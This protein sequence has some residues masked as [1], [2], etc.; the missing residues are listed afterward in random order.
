MGA[1][2]ETFSSIRYYHKRK[3]NCEDKE[4]ERFFGPV[5][6]SWL[7]VQSLP[8]SA[9]NTHLELAQ[10]RDPVI[11][12]V[13]GVILIL[14]GMGISLSGLTGKAIGEKSRQMELACTASNLRPG[15]TV[16]LAAGMVGLIVSL[17]ILVVVSSYASH[18]F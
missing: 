5:S 13:L 14:L 3:R 8:D 16:R 10:R 2:T 17:F 15:C 7:L 12:T 11:S 1:T 6:C 18:E 9:P 4:P